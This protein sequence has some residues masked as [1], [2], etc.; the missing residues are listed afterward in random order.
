[1]ERTH[2][3]VCSVTSFLLFILLIGISLTRTSCSM[4]ALILFNLKVDLTYVFY[5]TYKSIARNM[6]ILG[7][8]VSHIVTNILT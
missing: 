1:M 2:A 7:I 5:L 4:C 3:G 6:N 8:L